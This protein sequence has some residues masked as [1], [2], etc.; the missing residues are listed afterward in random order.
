MHAKLKNGIDFSRYI[1][2]L[3]RRINDIAEHEKALRR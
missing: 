3:R 1:K 2:Y